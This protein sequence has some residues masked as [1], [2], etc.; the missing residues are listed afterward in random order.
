MG[1]LAGVWK[2]VSFK[3]GHGHSG[4]QQKH[5]VARPDGVM[6]QPASHDI[7]Y[8]DEVAIE[9]SWKQVGDE[10]HIHRRWVH[11]DGTLQRET[12]QEMGIQRLTHDELTLTYRD[13]VATYVRETD[14]SVLAAHAEAPGRVPRR[15]RL[16]ATL[17]RLGWNANIGQWSGRGTLVG[18]AIPSF[19]VEL[20]EDADDAEFDAAC[21]R[22]LALLRRLDEWKE[23]AA[24][25]LLDDYNSEWRKGDEPELDR[26]AFMAR[27]TVNSMGI[28]R[29]GSADLY[30]N[31]GDL[32]WGHGIELWF[33]ADLEPHGEPGLVG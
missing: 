9:M 28:N 1:E 13:E 18:H 5:L 22:I 10:L 27:L 32:F 30:F 3:W 15:V 29:S 17:G 12:D 31:D 7:V 11:P 6:W 14:P 16:H 24:D 20:N 19:L 33:D 8:D 25:A 23:R 21:E 4:T 26:H 2:Q